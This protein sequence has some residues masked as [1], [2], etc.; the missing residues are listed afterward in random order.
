MAM[1]EADPSAW[2]LP[3]EQNLSFSPQ[4]EMMADNDRSEQSQ[5]TQG[6]QDKPDGLRS[7]TAAISSSC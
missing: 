4:D 7:E 1:I 3:R 6:Q 5:A 2:C